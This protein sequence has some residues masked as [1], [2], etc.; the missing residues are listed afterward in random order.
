MWRPGI[1]RFIT[2]FEFLTVTI[3]E[4]LE[5]A[6]LLLFEPVPV[7]AESITSAR[8]EGFW[9]SKLAE[10]RIA[11]RLELNIASEETVGLTMVS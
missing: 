2:L 4:F 1:Q 10:P 9:E 7:A 11:N 5:M 8:V 6:P 3:P